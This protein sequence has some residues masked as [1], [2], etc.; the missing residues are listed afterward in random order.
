MDSELI[1]LRRCRDGD[2]VEDTKSV[3]DAAQIPYR[4]GSTA[5][6]FDISTIGTGS[7]PEV[8]IS[9]R[10]A[11]FSAAR[12]AMEEEYLKVDLPSDHYLLTSPDEELAEILGKPVEWSPFDVA[13]ARKLAEARGI[14]PADIERQSEERAKRLKQGKPASGSLLFFGWLFSVLGG[15][16]GLGIA[17]SICFMKEKSPEGDFFTYDEKSREIAKP[18]FI[19]ACVMTGLA[20]ILRFSNIVSV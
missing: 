5:T 1:E 19:L 17:W 20:L 3:L 18:M 13:H 8:I 15:L 6:S 2:T 11:D 12:A 16:I 4:V 7:D 10:R 14:E 9:V